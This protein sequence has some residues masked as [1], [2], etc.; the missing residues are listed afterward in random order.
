M[1]SAWQQQRKPLLWL[2]GAVLAGAALVFALRSGTRQEAL[3]GTGDV[4]APAP[5][6]DAPDAPAIT[7]APASPDTP[8]W[9]AAPPSAPPVLGRRSQAT[10][11][12]VMTPEESAQAVARIRAQAATNERALDALIAQIDTLKSSGQVQPGVDIDALRANLVVARKAQALAQ[13]MAELTQQPNTPARQQQL[14]AITSQLQQL[15]S[16]LRYDVSTP[17]G[18]PSQPQTSGGM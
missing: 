10:S 11:E 9:L 4:A 5:V 1:S 2:A 16:Q 7:P 18:I 15:Q 3:P 14:N 8:P 12:P 13:E 17:D 6:A